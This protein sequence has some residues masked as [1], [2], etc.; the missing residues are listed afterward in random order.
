MHIYRRKRALGLSLCYPLGW[1]VCDPYG[2]NCCQCISASFVSIDPEPCF[3]VEK[4]CNL[5]DYGA[6]KSNNKRL[7]VEDKTAV[8]IIENTTH[9]MYGWYEVGMLLKEK[10]R[11]FPNNEA[12]AKHHLQIPSYETWQ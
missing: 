3:L 1:C 2:V 7:S 11:Q 8:K 4:F 6:V 12:M 5:E 9:C 10:K